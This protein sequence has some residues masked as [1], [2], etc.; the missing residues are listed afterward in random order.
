MII[1]FLMFMLTFLGFIIGYTLGYIKG[2]DFVKTK[3]NELGENERIK[4]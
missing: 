4:T 1:V 3:I 2:I